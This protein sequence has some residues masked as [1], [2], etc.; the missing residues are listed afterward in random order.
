MSELIIAG[1]G[2]LA[3]VWLA[4]HWERKVSKSQF[5]QTNLEKTID[6]ITTND[7]EPL[8]LRMSGQLLLGVVRIYSRKTRY[9]L[10]DCNEALVKIKLSFK[11]GNVNM[12][13]IQHTVA[14]IKSIT[15]PE[16]LTEFDILLPDEPLLDLEMDTIDAVLDSSSQLAS[17]QDITLSDI[18]F[19]GGDDY[20]FGFDEDW[21]INP[22][23]ETERARLAENDVDGLDVGSVEMGRRDNEE[24]FGREASFTEDNINEPLSKMNL[25][26]QDQDQYQ[27][28]Y[29]DFDDFDFGDVDN[30][31]F[32]TGGDATTTAFGT[33]A[34]GATAADEEFNR[35]FDDSQ[36]LS[37]NS[38]MQ[39]GLVLDDDDDQLM[40]ETQPLDTP[41]ESV[42]QQPRRQRRRRLVVDRVTEIPHDQ[43]RANVTDT[44]HLINRDVNLSQSNRKT[45]V[46]RDWKKPVALSNDT[47]L[48]QLYTQLKRKRNNAND[49]NAL[50]EQELDMAAAAQSPL[51]QAL[52]VPSDQPQQ[53]QDHDDDYMDFDDFDFGDTPAPATTTEQQ[54]ETVDYDND[55]YNNQYNNNTQ[56][57][58][59]TFSRSTHETLEGIQNRITVEKSVVSFG[60]LAP[61]HSATKSEAARRFYDVLL[62][63]TK[64][65][66]KVQQAQAFGEIQIRA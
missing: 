61:A 66:I 15:L 54:P 43:L 12:P 25:Q 63:T 30:N 23:A 16:R 44:S 53:Q 38:L 4:S 41:A 10:E 45:G 62:L 40:F 5:L 9:L 39:S 64:D 55:A 59:S 32:A 34:P 2:P 26:D 50:N 14:S 52:D 1:S 24:T 22:T 29:V 42:A 18:S 51:A 27:D 65:R 58:Q 11:K 60:E 48:G 19:T 49:D 35:V 17:S 8:T 31:Q 6:A 37:G 20:G 46:K 28:D 7:Q 47:K 36:S 33:A 56:S 57:S 21:G 13:D 3:R